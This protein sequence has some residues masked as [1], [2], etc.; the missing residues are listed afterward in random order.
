MLLALRQL[1][2]LGLGE[3][4][5]VRQVALPQTAISGHKSQPI[6]RQPT[7]PPTRRRNGS[8]TDDLHLP[9]A[10]TRGLCCV[11]GNE[12]LEGQLGTDGPFDALDTDA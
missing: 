12:N 8:G 10:R 4:G 9:A 6:M 2:P 1:M 7:K 3:P 11:G 5:V